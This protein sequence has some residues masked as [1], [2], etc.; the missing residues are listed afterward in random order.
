MTGHDKAS[1]SGRVVTFCSFCGSEEHG[2]PCP[3]DN[4]ESTTKLAAARK[5]ALA[6]GADGG[7]RVD[8]FQGASP[9]RT[10]SG[11]SQ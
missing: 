7:Y 9:G 10:S 8:A 2:F 3:L 5:A 4:E 6:K 1:C 11:A